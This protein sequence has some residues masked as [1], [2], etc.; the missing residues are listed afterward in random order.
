MKLLLASWPIGYGDCCEI[1]YPPLVKLFGAG[2]PGLDD[3]NAVGANLT[4][5]SE[6]TAGGPKS[7][8]GEAIPESEEVISPGL[9]AALAAILFLMM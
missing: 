8:A 3:G 5:K 7:R 1:T 6:S 9:A 2:N 4:P